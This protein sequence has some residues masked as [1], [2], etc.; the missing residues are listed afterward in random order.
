MVQDKQAVEIAEYEAAYCYCKT[1]I[2]F[3][4]VLLP[5]H[6]L[7]YLHGLNQQTQKRIFHT[8]R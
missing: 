7:R 8:L 6:M 2:E 1:M 4:I 5:K 3:Q